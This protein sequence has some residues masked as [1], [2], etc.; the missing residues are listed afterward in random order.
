MK[1]LFI[2]VHNLLLCL[3]LL[4]LVLLVM[5]FQGSRRRIP[6]ESTLFL[7]H[8]VHT[9]TKDTAPQYWLKIT[10]CHSMLDSK[11]NG[12]LEWSVALES[13]HD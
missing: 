6:K 10:T 5:E 13:I 7:G 1:Y 3:R 11:D 9:F 4:S 12:H 2:F 8:P